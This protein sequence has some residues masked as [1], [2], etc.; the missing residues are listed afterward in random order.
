MQGVINA[1]DVRKD[2]S[3]FIDD[4]VHVRPQFVKRNHDHWL[5]LSA[6]HARALLDNLKF[7]AQ[8]LEEDGSI[9]ATIDGFDIVVNAADRDLARK[10]LAE[11]LSEYAN[12]YFNE[13]RLY[14]Y[15]TNRQKHFPYILAVLIQDDLN[16]VISLIS[17]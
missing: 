13:F 12:E 10:A 16:G 5:A 11:Y 4:V 2:F 3:K 7:Q 6:I 14:Y 15:S 17:A 9:T 1:T 8:Y